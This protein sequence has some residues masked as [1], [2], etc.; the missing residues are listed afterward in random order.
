MPPPLIKRAT[1]YPQK[2]RSGR[3]TWVVNAGKKINRKSDLRRFTSQQ[4]AKNFKS[5]WNLKLSDQNTE[6]LADL[7]G[8]AR[9][10]VLAGLGKLKLVGATFNEAVDF[11]LR[12]GR[13]PR[14]KISIEQTIDAFLEAKRKKQRSEKYQKTIEHTTLLPFSRASPLPSQQFLWQIPKIW[15]RSTSCVRNAN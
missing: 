7:Q 13:P 3:S 4:D 1:V 8:I 11:F 15:V 14:C 5:E 9:H 10:E 12:F 2:H 6:A